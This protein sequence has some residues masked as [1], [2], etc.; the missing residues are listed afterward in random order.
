[1]TWQATFTKDT[2]LDD[3]GTITAT[4]TTPEG[5]SFTMPSERV[6]QRAGLADFVTRAKA[7]LAAYQAQRTKLNIISAKVTAALNA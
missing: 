5:E 3:V 7:G 1:M 6:N 4:W 2:E